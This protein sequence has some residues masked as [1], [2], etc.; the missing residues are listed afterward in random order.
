MN[1]K[2]WREVGKQSLYFVLL[3]A[4]IALL[5]GGIDLIQGRSFE[6]E[7]FII[8]LSLWLLTVSLFLGLSPFAL[9]S[10]QKGM[11]YLLTLPFSR[12]RLLFIKLLPRLAAL[13]F[14]YCLFLL[15]Y[16]IQGREVLGNAFVFFNLA[17]FALFFI[18]FSLASVHENF[19]VQFIS[20]GIAFSGYWA[21]CIFIL[22][23]GFAWQNN[24]SW[25]SVWRF[26]AFGDLFHEFK[27]LMVTLA[28]FS[29][30]LVP[31]VA[32]YFLAFK[33]FDLRPARAFNRRQLLFFVPLL[34]L[35][36]GVAL[37]I[38]SHLQ[39]SS[40]LDESDFYLTESG[41]LLK[42]SWP[43]KLTVHDE[44]GRKQIDTKKAVFWNRVLLEK[45]QQLFLLGYD[46]EDG[47]DIIIR[48]DMKDFSW[49]TLYRVRH[50]YVAG[51]T[52]FAFSYDGTGFVNLQRS[53]A[54]ADRPGL[55]PG[56]PIKSDALELVS[57]DPLS[58]KSRTIKFRSPLFKKYFEPHFFAC[59][60]IDGLGF[61]LISHRWSRII[62]LWED[63]RVEDLGLSQGLPA[64][65]K[66][67]LFSRGSGSLQ[68]RQLLDMGSKTIKEINGEFS[69]RSNFHF[70]QVNNDIGEIYAKRGKRI[71]RLDLTTLAIDDVGS[72]RGLISL[73]PPGDFYYVEHEGWPHGQVQPD[74]WR[75]IYRL[76]GGKMIFIKQVDFSKPGQG[77]VWVDKF[78]IILREK[79]KTRIFAFPDLREL[80]FKK[81]N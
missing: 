46:T 20:V 57:F 43:G 18:S 24:L 13:T 66:H 77:H 6:S 17:S 74:R 37:G 11:E 68:V 48:L 45:R 72:D 47:S 78:G 30:L 65:F 36:L 55:Q 33:K 23:S 62:R 16:Q 56:L 22:A 1:K 26:S 5:I 79:G 27:G 67:L 61:W 50:R 35:A 80:K 42:A 75:K 60:Q 21:L 12:R 59:D 69:L 76:Q 9:D 49:K 14:F 64:Y 63:G 53:R 38:S 70:L 2:E 31:F 52:F 10:K 7:K 54:E 51:N 4:G 81:L 41:Q 34:L 73:V 28:V 19:I 15:L 58:G 25:A 8:M 40:M 32:S 71:V 39:K 44:N 3:V 29:L